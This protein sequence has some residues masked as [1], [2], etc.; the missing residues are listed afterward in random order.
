M[1]EFRVPQS[2]KKQL[3]KIKS[4]QLNIFINKL[5]GVLINNLHTIYLYGSM[6]RKCY[7]KI[8]SD[9]DV[10]VIA[11]KNYNEKEINNILNIH[12]KTTLPIDSTFI[13]LNQLNKNIYPAPISFAVKM[14]KQL[15]KHKN[16]SKDF[17][18][19]RQDIFEKGIQLIKQGQ[20]CK[21]NKVPWPLIKKSINYIFPHIRTRFKNPVLSLCR[22]VY[23]MR[24][25]KLC[26]KIEAGDW[27]LKNIDVRFHDIIRIDLK[28]Y[29]NGKKRYSIDN[30]LLGELV[31]Y[32]RNN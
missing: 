12:K 26:S 16:G 6:A 28:N 30:K 21:I 13:T 11:C 17:L 24:N 25:K 29:I 9:I 23:T 19:Q 8:T 5:I 7:N 31:E 1:K 18:L 3:S 14:N 2:I 32:C 22:Y 15:I 4:G 10:L 20:G 27:A